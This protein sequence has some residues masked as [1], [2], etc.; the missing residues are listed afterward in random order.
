M[1]GGGAVTGPRRGVIAADADGVDGVTR[2][3]LRPSWADRRWPRVS[4]SA[5]ADNQK[6]SSTYQP[7]FP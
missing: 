1:R 2:A 7:P 6:Y 5:S 3:E 4:S